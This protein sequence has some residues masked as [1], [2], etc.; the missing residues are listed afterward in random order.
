VLFCDCLR[1][2]VEQEHPSRDWS[3]LTDRLYRCY[4]RR[5]E[6][7]DASALMEQARQIFA[8]HPAALAVEWGPLQAG[9]PERSKPNPAQ[10]NLADVF[11][12]YFDSFKNACDSA[13]SFWDAFKIY[14]PVR[15]VI[16]DL[17]GFARN[18]NKPLAE[19]DLLEGKPFW[20]Q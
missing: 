3:L 1:A 2:Y 11:S 14:Q 5:E 16:F 9:D 6:L 12:K 20:L 4:L 19:Y 15:V 18:K 7:D 10:P 17:P 13:K 8:G